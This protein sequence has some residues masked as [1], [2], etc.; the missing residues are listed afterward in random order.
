LKP[1]TTIALIL[2]GGVSAFAQQT[3]FAPRVDIGNVP[4]AVCSIIFDANNDGRQDFAVCAS[5]FVYVFLQNPGPVG[6][7]TLASTINA[8]TGNLVVSLG[9]GDFNGDGKQDLAVA[10]NTLFTSSGTSSVS[11]YP[12]SGNGLFLAPSTVTSQGGLG[13]MVVTDLNNDHK[14]DIVVASQSNALIFLGNGTGGFSGP[15]LLSVS[16]PLSALAV[17]DFNHN[18]VPDVARGS[19]FL[20]NG[21]GTLGV[22]SGPPFYAP[23]SALK[24]V[25][26]NSILYLAVADVNNDGIPDIVGKSNSVPSIVWLG[27][28]DGTFQ[29]AVTQ[30]LGAAAIGFGV[31][32]FNF[33]GRPDY[34]DLESGSPATVNIFTGTGGG[35]FQTTPLSFPACNTTVLSGFPATNALT[36]GDL[37][38]D[39]IPDVI[40]SCAASSTVSLFLSLAPA[41]FLQTSANPTTP[42][43]SVTL[44]SIVGTPAMGFLYTSGFNVQFYDGATALGSPIQVTSGQATRTTTSLPQGIHFLTASLLNSQGTAVS[45]SGIVTQVVSPTTCAPNL[46]GQLNIV[47]GG[48]RR[49]PVTGQYIQTVTVTNTSGTAVMGPV[50]LALNNLSAGVTALNADGLTAWQRPGGCAVRR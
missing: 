18:G 24:G 31:A 8:G 40:A 5:N 35:Q 34:V 29:A 33:D 44:T 25:V 49:N 32:D 4:G 48:F 1:V 6:T 36:V 21:D 28:G 14:Q 7:F 16:T 26:T 43:Q 9:A 23:N 50:S 46:A 2:L 20:G 37:N 42:G 45:T 10:T 30:N 19:I 17:G 3:I 22:V 39:G 41:V 38:G 15:T 13:A 11:V 12:G 47:P 27:N